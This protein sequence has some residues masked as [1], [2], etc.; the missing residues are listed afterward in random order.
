MSTA[1]PE[2]NTSIVAPPSNPQIVDTGKPP[3]PAPAD[4]EASRISRFSQYA[5]RSKAANEG[6][7]V[8]PLNDA[9]SGPTG[10]TQDVFTTKTDT[11][12]DQDQ[13]NGQRPEHGNKVNREE[14]NKALRQKLEAETK[15][16]EEAETRAKTVQDRISE[17][18]KKNEEWSLTTKERDEL[19]SKYEEESRLRAEK[20]QQLAFYDITK[21]TT[22]QNEIEAPLKSRWAGVDEIVSAHKLDPQTFE[23]ALAEPDRA[24]RSQ[25]L[26]DLMVDLPSMDKTELMEHYRGIKEL[27]AK[28]SS[29]QK[30]AQ[31]SYHAIQEQEK[32]QR[33]EST[34][35]SREVQ[36]KAYDA[37]AEELIKKEHDPEVVKSVLTEIRGQDFDSQ[38]PDVKAMAMLSMHLLVNE[39]PK[40]LEQMKEKDAKIKEL[41]EALGRY[42]NRPG[43]NPIQTNQNQQATT[44]AESVEDREARY[45]SWGPFANRR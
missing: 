29:M 43:P 2:A 10:T 12:P 30:N 7:D 36:Q 25:M 26:E 9:P 28:G 15:A 27:W 32:K 45:R 5:E 14:S 17:L 33:E 31:E 40:M 3:M 41:Q 16:R 4:T 44:K 6:R 34:A 19:K 23:R 22:Y 38:P 13:A 11:G 18:E 24:K 39:K 8:P 20:E 35:K 42:N 21:T 37:V 1:A